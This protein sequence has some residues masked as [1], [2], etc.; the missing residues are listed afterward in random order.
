MIIFK[1]NTRAQKDSFTEKDV[2]TKF[3]Q[4]YL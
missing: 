3:A 1:I 4:K 2:I